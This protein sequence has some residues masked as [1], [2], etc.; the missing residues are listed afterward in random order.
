MGSRILHKSKSETNTPSLFIKVS[1]SGVL[2]LWGPRPYSLSLSLSHKCS[3]RI[4][5]QFYRLPLGLLRPVFNNSIFHS[6]RANG[7]QNQKRDD[8][9]SC[10]VKKCST[11]S[12]LN[13]R[14]HVFSNFILNG[15]FCSKISKMIL[16]NFLD[17]Y[18]S[19]QQTLTNI[20]DKSPWILILIQLLFYLF[21]RKKYVQLIYI[22][23]SFGGETCFKRS[24]ELI[25]L[26]QQHRL[27]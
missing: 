4:V 10:R 3:S 14:S 23:W 22:C 11:V 18:A 8:N 25:K 6:I 1:L 26:R 7:K 20:L 5:F 2:L 17:W 9:C 24:K 19:E 16:S 12:R 13:P 15:C 21:R 27:L